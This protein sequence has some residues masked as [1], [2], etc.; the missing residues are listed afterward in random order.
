MKIRRATPA[1]LQEIAEIHIQSWK[2]AYTQDLPVEFI[3]GQIER[4]LRDHWSAIEIQKEDIVLVAQ[5]DAPIGFIAVW[6]RP[7]P[8]I[9]NLHVKPLYRSKKAGTALMQ[10]AAEKLLKKGHKTAYLWVFASNEKAI[11]FYEKL[12]GILKERAQ[13]DVF[14]Y[15]VLSQKM[16]WVDLSRIG[17]NPS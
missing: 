4:V 13:I 12:G 8:F 11:R 14:G 10:A 3:A 17:T 16:E 7:V 15:E 1:D 9:D 2:D 6:C 5:D